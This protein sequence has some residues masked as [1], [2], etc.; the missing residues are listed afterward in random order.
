MYTDLLTNSADMHAITRF[1]SHIFSCVS[2]SKKPPHSPSL[3][4]QVKF[5]V[6][7]EMELTKYNNDVSIAVG[8][9]CA[10]ATLYSGLQT[11]A[12]SRRA[13]KI[14]IDFV[15]LIKFV[16]F[17]CGNLANTFFV[18]TFGA[19]LWWWIFYKVRLQ[20]SVINNNQ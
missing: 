8:V 7:Y 10:L 5:E 15:T 20:T 16:L 19:S 3:L 14:A 11:W 9:L 6:T 17:A 12:W 18:V 1:L 2:E 4:L 13:G